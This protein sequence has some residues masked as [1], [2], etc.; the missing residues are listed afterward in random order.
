MQ[1]AGWKLTPLSCFV[2]GVVFANFI[3]SD[4]PALPGSS[5]EAKEFVENSVGMRFIK[6]QPGEFLM[7]S[8]PT[9]AHRFACEQQH[10]VRI[11]KAYWLGMEEV[12]VKQYKAVVGKSLTNSEDQN[13]PEQ[14]ISWYDA[15]DFTNRLS[16]LEAEKSAGRSY[17]LPT[18]AEWE[19]ACRAGTQTIYSWGDDPADGREFAWAATNSERVV[20][21]AGS[22]KPNAW[23]FH[24]MHGSVWEWCSDWYGELPAGDEID[25]QG[26]P[27]GDSKVIRGGSFSLPF[28]YLRS[29]SRVPLAPIF[30]SEGEGQSIGLRL[31]LMLQDEPGETSA[32]NAGTPGNGEETGKFS[33]R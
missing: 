24:D 7:G 28:S 32:G 27:S 15:Q 1:L 14:G 25:P 21:R 2:L 33:D 30:L 16:Q 17:R 9:E 10:R 8:P 20:K 13:V 18:E 12:T 23:G 11:T 5:R 19:Y 6:V 29:A 3:Y 22:L 26:P 4:E 31:V